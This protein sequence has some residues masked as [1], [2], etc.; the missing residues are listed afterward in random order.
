MKVYST[1]EEYIKN[2]DGNLL[3]KVKEIRALITSLVPKGEEV[4]KYG[5]PTI[6]IGG[7]N[8]IHYAA[9]KGH[10]GFY[11]TPSGVTAYADELA[12][13]NISYS[14]GCIRFSYNEPLPVSLIKKIVAFRLKEEKSL[15]RASL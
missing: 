8:F 13:R 11:P 6:R 2:V 12:K 4:I 14:K 9:M 1:V 10:I 3:P 15:R 5:M 7:K